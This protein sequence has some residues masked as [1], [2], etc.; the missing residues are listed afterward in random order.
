MP[1]GHGPVIGLVGCPFRLGGVQVHVPSAFFMTPGIAVG[2]PLA[3]GAGAAA[4]GGAV[5][6]GAAGAGAGAGAGCW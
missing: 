2:V 3:D 4:G 6:A 1:G 5:V